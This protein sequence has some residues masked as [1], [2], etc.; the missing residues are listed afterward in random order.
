MVYIGVIT[1]LL[2]FCQLPGTSKYRCLWA[3]WCIIALVICDILSDSMDVVV[4]D[5]ECSFFTRHRCKVTNK[6]LLY[7][8]RNLISRTGLDFICGSSN[9]NSI[10][11][12]TLAVSW[13]VLTC[14]KIFEVAMNLHDNKQH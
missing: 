7:C 1:H 5:N 2:T 14:K 6:R 9:V 13:V 4:M 12:G 10:L 3:F 8:D 11:N